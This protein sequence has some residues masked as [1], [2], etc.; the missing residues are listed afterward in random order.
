MSIGFS[1]KPMFG[2]MAMSI[3]SFLV[4]TNALRLNLFR[5]DKSKKIKK[6]KEEETDAMTINEIKETVI[7]IDGM[8]CPHCSGRVKALLLALEGVSDADVSHERG[9]AIITAN[10]AFDIEAA[11]REIENAG[12]SVIS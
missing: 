8:M 3:S 1:L 6:N 11:R 12:Y 4:V 2:A 5:G 9:D 10:G 7:K